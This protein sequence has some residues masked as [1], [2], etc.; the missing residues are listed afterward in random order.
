MMSVPV[1][2]GM[3]LYVPVCTCD[4]RNLNFFNLDL[5][6]E[7]LLLW[8]VTLLQFALELE[9]LPWC[10][11]NF[12]VLLIVCTC[13]YYTAWKIEKLCCI[14]SLKGLRLVHFFRGPLKELANAISANAVPRLYSLVV[15]VKCTLSL[16]RTRNLKPDVFHC[17]AYPV[18]VLSP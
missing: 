2:T 8:S 9:E 5:I 14:A 4:I 16:T 15:R 18:T 13:T 6:L 1:R 7:Y 3:Y 17:R 10:M 11:R 12:H